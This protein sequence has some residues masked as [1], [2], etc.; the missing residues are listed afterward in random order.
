MGISTLLRKVMFRIIHLPVAKDLAKLT[1]R[2]LCSKKS[3][4]MDAKQFHSV[5]ANLHPRPTGR[6][7]WAENEQPVWGPAKYDLSIIIPFYKTEQYAHNCIQSVLS[8]ETTFH[9]ELILINDGS[10]DNC[11]AILDEYDSL[12]NVT[13]IHQPNQGQSAARNHGLQIAAG[14]Y[15]MFL[16]S[17]DL[18]CQ[19][20]IQTLMN[21]ALE[22]D[23]DI[24]EG[25]YQN[26]SQNGR[27]KQLVLHSE[28]LGT[29]GEGM[30]GFPWGKVFRRSLFT[31]IC[32]PQGYWFEDTIIAALLFPVAP[33]T[34]TV[35]HLVVMYRRNL[36]G[37]SLSSKKSP[38]CIDAYYIM[39]EV[40]S[41]INQLGL[42][43][44]RKGFLL[45]LGPYLNHRIQSLSKQE[46]QAAFLLAADL[47]Q[48][49]DLTSNLEGASY[50]Q[51]QLAEA[52]AHRRYKQWKW[53]CTLM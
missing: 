29:Q 17:D 4:E 23:A 37:I 41:S 19:G 28:K 14:N 6:A 27:L 35:S 31:N 38:K 53:V 43:I 50:Y 36:S 11:P 15:I 49:Y 32:F 7:L 8:Q 2:S 52:L 1:Y 3:L 39:E 40:F 9:Y 12:T 47:A 48:K 34:K 5:T 13:V 25:S 44:N 45:Q 46:T 10:P 24:V 20:S 26:M 16:D 51:Q 21:S 42:P 33:V 22:N 18:L 30:F